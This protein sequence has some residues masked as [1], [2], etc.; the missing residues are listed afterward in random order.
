MLAALSSKMLYIFLVDNG[1]MLN[2]DV[3]LA[4]KSVAYLR[5]VIAS[6]FGIQ[7]TKQ[8]RSQD[9]DSHNLHFPLC[10]TY[11]LSMSN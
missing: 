9:K 1:S 4:L 11:C 7:E 6:A 2:L 5:S 10:N 3:D 8:V